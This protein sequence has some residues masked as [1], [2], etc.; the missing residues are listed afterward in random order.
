MAENE[1]WATRLES[2]QGFMMLLEEDPASLAGEKANGKAMISLVIQHMLD[3]HHKVSLAALA[4]LGVLVESSPALL[5]TSKSDILPKVFTKLA[6]PKPQIRQ[7]ANGL[8]TK[9]R[10]TFD[11]SEVCGSICPHLMDF[12]DKARCGALEFLT[13]LCPSAPPY[14]MAP[15]NLRGLIQRLTSMAHVSS[16][17]SQ[18]LQE[19][20]LKLLLALQHM[21]PR[22]F[23]AQIASLPDQAQAR[24]QDVLKKHLTLPAKVTSQSSQQTKPHPTRIRKGAANPVPP[25]S[26]RRVSN[27]NLTVVEM[28][29]DLENEHNNHSYSDKSNKDVM[30][31][32]KTADDPKSDRLPLSEITSTVENHPPLVTAPDHY[33]RKEPHAGEECLG[34][35]APIISVGPLLQALGAGSA[36]PGQSQRLLAMRQIVQLSKE[37]NPEIW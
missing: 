14:L 37:N 27:L 11:I 23:E 29:C 34:L 16:R 28:D 15:Q 3:K 6:D 10:Q 31:G 22:L 24:A 9:L 25:A 21:D 13:T 8:L 36:T 7:E 33:T 35:G 5:Q 2:F 19:S 20:A 18:M 32:Q 4:T 26:R 12:P 17:G 1:H 30:Q